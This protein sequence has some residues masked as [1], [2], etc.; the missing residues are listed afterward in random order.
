MTTKGKSDDKHE[1][2]DSNLWDTQKLCSFVMEIV[3]TIL[4]SMNLVTRVSG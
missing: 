3:C 2:Y 4:K 1:V